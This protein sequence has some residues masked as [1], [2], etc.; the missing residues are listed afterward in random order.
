LRI[1]LF[2]G[3][4]DP[5]HVGHLR[6]ARAAARLLHLDQVLFVPSASPPHKLYHRLT[7]YAHRFS[8]VALACGGKGHFVP[9][10]LEAP[11]SDG[12]PQYSVSTAQRLKRKLRRADRLFFLI[13]AD[14]FLDL[15]HWKDYDRLLGLADFIVVSRPGFSVRDIRKVVPSGTLR[16]R[17]SPRGMKTFRLRRTTL[18]VIESMHVAVAAREIR[19]RVEAGLAVTELVPPLVED[20]IKKEGLYRLDRRGRIGA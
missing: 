7:P 12:Q 4:F 8:M 9:S 3:T 13:G 1:A 19:K 15:P 16:Q 17:K 20:Y 14:A 2:G 6:A 10:L 5:I 18:H 11:S